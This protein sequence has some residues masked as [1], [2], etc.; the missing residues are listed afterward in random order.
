MR[1]EEKLNIIQSNVSKVYQA[2]FDVGS[3][4]AGSKNFTTGTVTF[5]ETQA[6]QTVTHNLGVIPNFVVMYPKDLSVIPE[7]GTPEVANTVYKFMQIYS[8][9]LNIDIGFSNQGNPNSFHWVWGATNNSANA[10]SKVDETTFTT[11]ATTAG[12]KY[13]AGIEFEWIA[14]ELEGL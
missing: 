11:G 4:S 7:S 10:M 2:G 1:L 14:M 12:Y 5:T 13:P 8:D 6:K 9:K 3:L